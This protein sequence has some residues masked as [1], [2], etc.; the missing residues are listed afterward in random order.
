MA[1]AQELFKSKV[2]DTIKVN[3]ND[4]I[5]T[6]ADYLQLPTGQ[7]SDDEADVVDK[8]FT[9]KLLGWLGYEGGDDISDR[10]TPAQPGNRPDFVV[11]ILGSTAF[12]VEDKST[13][14]KFDEKSIKQLRRYTAGTAGY[15]LWTNAKTILG[16]RFDPDG[17]YQTLVEVRVDGAFGHDRL[18]IPQDANFEILHLLFHRQR[19]TDITGLI[20]AVAIDEDAW[21]QQAKPLTDEQSIRGFINESRVVLDQLVTTI[22]ARLNTVTIELDEA[23]RDATASQQQYATIVRQLIE[24]L[25]GIIKPDV[26]QRLE[27]HLRTFEPVLADVDI[28]QIERLKPTMGEV[29][30]TIWNNRIQEMTGVISSL[31]ERELARVESR[32]IRAAYLLWRERYKIIE[33]EDG[34]SEIEV[35]IRRQRAFA[36]QVSYVFFVRLLLTRVLEDKGIMPHL[37]SD[38]GFQ[39]WHEFSSGYALDG[40]DEIVGTAFLHL[41][42]RRV[43]SSYRHFFQQ[44]VFDWFVPDDY[45]LALVLQ[46]LNSYNFKDVTSDLLGYTYEHFIERIARNK[47]GH[48]LTPPSVV[49][50]MLDQAGYNTSAIIG[51]SLLDPAC[52][53]GSFLVHAARRLKK[54]LAVA[55]ANNSPLE[56]AR[57]FIEQ[58]QT[59][60]VGLEI[61]PFS[62]YLAELNLFIQVLDDL[63]LLWQHGEHPD[64]ERFAIYN[65][66]SLEMPQAV[67]YSGRNNIATVFENYMATLDDASAV[68]AQK[69]QFSFV[70]CNPPYVNRGIVLGA[71]SYGDFPFYSDVVK[72]DENFYLLFFRLA[73]YY[74]A[75]GGTVCFICPLNLLGDESTM[76]T[77]EMFSMQEWSITSLTRFYA[78]TILFPG[79]LQGVCVV[80]FDNTASQFTDMVEVRGGYSVEEAAKTA[81]PVQRS[82]IISNYPETT[83][84]TKPWLVN[85]NPEIYHL[86]EDVR[87]H[88]DQSLADLMSGKIKAAKGDARSTWA[89]P[90]LVAGP[91]RK[92]IPLTKGKHI[93]DWGDWT[94]SAYLDPSVLIP[95]TVNDYTSCLWVQRQ[96]QRIANISQAETALFL[97]EVSGLEMKRP[98]RGT[99]VLRDSH[100]PVVADETVLVLYT[101]D[102]AYEELAYA[103]FG[104]ITS[105]TYNFLFSLFSTNAH[106][107]FKEILRL[108]VP[109]WSASLQQQL[110]DMT[111]D[112]LSAYRQLYAHEKDFGSGEN[113]DERTVSVNAVLTSSKLPTMRLE[114]LV[115]R[116]DVSLS[117]SLQYTLEVL[118]NRGQL[119]INPSLTSDAVQ[120]IERLVRANGTLTYAKGGKDLLFPNLRVATAFLS[121]L[122]TREQ[123]RETLLQI[124]METQHKLESDIMAAYGI[125]KRP[126]IE[127]IEAGVPWA[128]E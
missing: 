56:R 125:T 80:R 66:N 120:A 122:R 39:R 62:C 14:E 88:A 101:L 50:F 60:L 11:K 91:S 106:A 15:A 22:Q 82:R 38:G 117:G 109:A 27:D 112:T 49:E 74:V 68:K 25:R 115:L 23:I 3:A 24:K 116:G 53:S 48:F 36:E 52:G 92:T 47:K 107:N 94:A 85:A 46:R 9:Q 127:A 37:V 58:V 20:A 83:A 65:T 2:I 102:S 55:M 72:G 21:R 29:A 126:W 87:S 59:R 95:N 44:P 34:G 114:E 76:R 35:E 118:I 13:V 124:A 81:V 5:F 19:F 70:I 121:I 63:A 119:A 75:P 78:R 51:E 96:V 16:L 61:N 17:Q 6:Y 89:K 4:N 40:L 97:K 71:K 45:L 73:T 69:E 90:M 79:V 41:V 111:K 64:I 12:V 104:L 108:P 128:R 67:L 18:P 123:E 30:A 33:A 93:V 31:R 7:R 28:L 77:R 99:L 57:I 110:A 10:R 43:A 1:T 113:G 26:L 8:Q 103:T 84:W 105:L 100:H 54:V 98:I 32:R 42:Y 86:W